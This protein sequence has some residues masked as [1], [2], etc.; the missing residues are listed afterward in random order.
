MRSVNLYYVLLLIRKQ[1]F[2]GKNF[3]SQIAMI[4]ANIGSRVNFMLYYTGL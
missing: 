4:V 3:L 2:S 1:V